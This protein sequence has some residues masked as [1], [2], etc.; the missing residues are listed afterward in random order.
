MICVVSEAESYWRDLLRPEVWVYL[1]DLGGEGARRERA[2][3]RARSV[4]RARFEALRALNDAYQ[5]KMQR[6]Q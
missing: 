2:W 6:K 5:R 4:E 3:G 1:I